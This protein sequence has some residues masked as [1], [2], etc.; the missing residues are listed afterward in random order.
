MVRNHLL[1]NR[2]AFAELRNYWTSQEN[3]LNAT[4][5]RT[6]EVT[7]IPN[8]DDMVTPLVPSDNEGISLIIQGTGDAV[9]RPREGDHVAQLVHVEQD[10]TL[11]FFVTLEELYHGIQK[12]VVVMVRRFNQTTGSYLPSIKVVTIHVRPRWRSGTRII[13]EDEGAELG[14][15]RHQNLVFVLQERPHQRFRREGNNLRITV[16]LT[17]N[18]AL[19]GFR[20]EIKTLDGRSLWIQNTNPIDSYNQEHR[21]RHEGMVDFQ[22]GVRGD[23]IIFYEIDYPALKG[24]N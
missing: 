14:E 3:R 10:V 18:E 23:L 21:I 19:K 20:K 1:S 7:N 9:N 8:G 5:Q 11:P 6:D 16:N 2:K 13:V 4:A 12:P 22:N 15:G 17:L 24:T